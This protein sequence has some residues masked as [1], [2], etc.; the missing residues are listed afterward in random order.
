MQY[1]FIMYT[2]EITRK[3]FQALFCLVR[4]NSVTTGKNAHHDAFIP[5]SSIAPLFLPGTSFL[6]A[7]V[8]LRLAKEKTSR[9][10]YLAPI[11]KAPSANGTA[12]TRVLLAKCPVRISRPV[13]KAGCFRSSSSSC[14]PVYFKL[15]YATNASDIFKSSRLLHVQLSM[16]VGCGRVSMYLFSILQLSPALDKLRS[17]RFVGACAHEEGMLAFPNGHAKIIKVLLDTLL[18]GKYFRHTFQ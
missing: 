15:R 9:S 6:P 12:E 7:T 18:L 13:R 3:C 17:T 16:L 10:C 2:I 1:P 11:C 4:I 5:P 8:S 14:P